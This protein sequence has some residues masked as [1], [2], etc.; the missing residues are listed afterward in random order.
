MFI[1]PS[2]PFA[3]KNRKLVVWT[4]LSFFWHKTCKR[5]Y[6]WIWVKWSKEVP[7]SNARPIFKSL[8]SFVSKN[9]ANPVNPPISS[10]K[11]QISILSFRLITLKS[12]KTNYSVRKSLPGTND[13]WIVRS[14][15]TLFAFIFLINS[16]CLWIF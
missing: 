8:N 4:C 16:R 6:Y 9:G 15:L 5:F 14:G 11:K 2:E 3:I 12:A 1:T 7:S 13:K 10:S